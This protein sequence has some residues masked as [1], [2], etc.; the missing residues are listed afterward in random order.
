MSTETLII[1]RLTRVEEKIDNFIMRM[2]DQHDR[3]DDHEERL[4]SLE[5]GSSRLI[6]IGAA[7]MVVI[8]IVGPKISALL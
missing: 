2:M 8:S 1:E 4:R 6:G 3:I 5:A 7:L